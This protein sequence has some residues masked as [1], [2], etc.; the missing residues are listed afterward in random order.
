VWQESSYDLW[1]RKSNFAVLYPS[2]YGPVA[3]ASGAPMSTNN[4]AANKIN[5]AANIANVFLFIFKV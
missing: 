1:C 5:W 4:D 2:S 3:Y